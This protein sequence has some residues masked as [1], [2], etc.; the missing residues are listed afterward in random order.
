[1]II[2]KLKV[3][4]FR[5]FSA[6][7]IEPCAETNIICGDNAVGKT[8]II[9]AIWMLTGAKSFKNVRDNELI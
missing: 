3:A 5:N 9:E 1:M 7:E 4:D 2:K 6:C 8:N